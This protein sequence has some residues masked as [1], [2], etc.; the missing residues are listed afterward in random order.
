[1]ERQKR[2]VFHVTSASP[3]GTV[4]PGQ[5]LHR[6]GH[7][8]RSVPARHVLGFTQ[9]TGTGVTGICSLPPIA[10]R[11]APSPAM[12]DLRFAYLMLRRNPGVTIVAVLSLALG[13]GANTTVLCW[14]QNLVLQPLPGV[15]QPERMV[16][17]TTSHGVNPWDTVSLPDLRDCSLLGDVFA[18]VI[19]SQ[20]TPA[21]LSVDRS[22]EWI[23]GQLA[24]G[25]FFDV[26][27]VKPILGRTFVPAEDVKPGGHPVLVI[28][29]NL[30]RRRFDGD[31]E[32]IERVV[33]LNQH[34]F[35]IIGV[36]PAEFA[37]TMHGLEADFWAP[38]MMHREVAYPGIGAEAVLERHSRWFH[39]QARLQ[40][41]VS[42]E[43]ARAAVD[44]LA[45][46][47][48]QTYPES[49]R[50]IRLHVMPLWRSLYGA[51]EVFLPVLSLLLVVSMGVLLIVTAN[52]ANLL[53]AR[54]TSR[55]REMGIRQAVG[56]SRGR[57]IRQLLTESVLLALLGGA[58]GV[59]FAYW[60]VDLFQYFM[61]ETHLPLDLTLSITPWALGVS[62]VLALVT[63]LLFGLAPALQASRDQITRAL[64]DGGRGTGS[65]PAHHRARHLLVV[66]EVALALVLLAGAAL[67][68]RGQR[69]S[70]R[71]DPGLD[72]SGVLLAALRVGM[73]GYPPENATHF[74]RQ[75]RHRL[76][77]LPGVEDVALADW[78][79]LGFE[80][81]GT[82]QVEVDGRPRG[83]G[84]EL[85]F[86]L[87]IVSPRYFATLRIP[88]VA[89]RD[90]DDRDDASALRVAIINEAVARLLWPGQDPLGRVLRCDGRPT[91]VI[92]VA[93]TGKYRTLSEPAQPFLYLPHQQATWQLNLGLCLR[94]RGDCN[95]QG[96]TVDPIAFS[97]IL[98]EEIRRLDPGVEVWKMLRM[99]DY[100]QAAYLTQRIASA[101]L[102]LLGI[103]ALAL[104]TMG[105]YAVV[106]YAVSQ[107]TREYG[108][109]MALGATASDIHR[110]VLLH[111]LRLTAAGVAAGLALALAV[112][113]LLSR[114]LYGVSPFDF[115]TFA[116]VALLLALVAVV[117]C[118]LPARRATRVDPIAALRAE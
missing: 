47:L 63:G 42:L 88:L 9:L 93:R 105:V 45:S 103:V 86:P 71:I 100:V 84:D 79:P 55:R 75:L 94:V 25:N 49:N 68:L 46:R 7:P 69:T 106:A 33:D 72:P 60:M 118:W 5:A 108:V 83:L 98:R 43:Q 74:Y 37:G 32:I 80:D 104:A 10:Y 99:T 40:P 65:G 31:P 36:A 39:T 1:M 6:A 56:A 14:L 59:F 41:G 107:R 70:Q 3:V 62:L 19:G 48:E 91:T 24:T 53:L 101:L 21:C 11:P 57:L 22:Q 64:H 78:F 114:F 4:K 2:S 102:T 85:D 111:G 116:G 50:S 82:S 92:G 17:L 28:S 29:E 66:T 38:A 115:P 90:F 112:T 96:G 18:G 16:A 61:P 30:W 35:T 20:T 44:T 110:Q 67:C 89:G 51:Q 12:N 81:T 15:V 27:G 58:L 54:A 109:R 97:G 87:G 76:S 13:I 8:L 73:N 95:E 113:R 23:Y 117:A 26:L 34:A 52:V 77:A